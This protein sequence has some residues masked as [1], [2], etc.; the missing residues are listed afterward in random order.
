M[1]DYHAGEKIMSKEEMIRNDMKLAYDR[2][3][4]IEKRLDKLEKYHNKL[5]KHHDETMGIYN[6]RIDK[7][8]NELD[9]LRKVVLFDIQPKLKRG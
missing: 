8:E 9:T 6:A 3:V 4:K 2:I 5:A 1:K 7:L